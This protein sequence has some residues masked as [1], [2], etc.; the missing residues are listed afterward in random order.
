M[1]LY[2]HYDPNGGNYLGEGTHEVVIKDVKFFKYA[3]G[4]QG[5]EFHVED[6]MGKKQKGSFALAPTA[7]WKLANFAADLGLTEQQM[8]QIDPDR[9]ATFN[10]FRGK[11]CS[12]VVVKNGQYHEIKA[13]G[14]PS[15]PQATQQAP[16]AAH[17]PAEQPAVNNSGEVPAPNWDNF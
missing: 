7:L 1:S 9:G 2:D 10:V 14:K 3:K 16:Q 12:V 15:G 8:R 17:E 5:V 13:W 11:R 6:R 4:S